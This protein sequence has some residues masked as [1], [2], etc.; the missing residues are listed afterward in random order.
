[1]RFAVENASA[2]LVDAFQSVVAARPDAVAAQAGHRKL[3][4]GQLDR[5][6]ADLARRLRELRVGRDA[7]VGVIAE[8]GLETVVAAVAVAKAGGAYAPLDPD[9]PRRRTL[10][11]LAHVR[12]TAVVAP[13]SLVDRVTG[14][15]VP[16]IALE[17]SHVDDDVRADDE[18][19]GTE[20][21]PSDLFAVVF[22]SGSSGR[23]K[24]VA[25]EHRNLLNLIAGAAE[26]LP[27]AGEGAL[28]ICA[29]QFDL[30]I[31]E[32]WATLLGGGRLVCHP[33]G[34]PD[35][36]A[37]R[38]TIAD[39]DVGWAFMATS[40][41]HQ[42]VESG[43]EELA[44]L[45]TL[46]AGGEAMHTGYARRFRA[47]CPGTQLINLYGPAETTVC[48]TA[49][50]VGDEVDGDAP[51]PIGRALAGALLDIRGPEGL[52]VESGAKGELWVGGAGV[53][54][55]YLHDPELTAERFREGPDEE[56][57]YR[58]GDIV[59]AREDGVL[60][61]FGRVDDQVKLRGY[62]VEPLEVEAHVL[63]CAGVARAAVVVQEPA[64]GR[65]RLA[66]FVVLEAGATLDS[67]RAELAQSLPAYMIPGAIVSV[68]E[69][70]VTP[71]GK[72]DRV[73]LRAAPVSTPAAGE[74]AVGPLTTTIAAV[75]AEV[76][77]VPAVGADDDFFAL[78]GDSLLAL[79]VVARL[80]ARHG[81]HTP[82][83]AI[84]Q[85]RTPTVVAAELDEDSGPVL[86]PLRARSHPE[87]VPA[88]AGQA[89]ALYVSELAEE[90]LP[91]QSQALHRIRGRLDVGALE[92][93]LSAI[94]ERHEILRTTFPRVD[95]RFVQSVHDPAPVRLHIEDLRSVADPE[96]ALEEH[97][98]DVV[99]LRLDPERLPLVRWSL[100]RVADD[101]HALIAVEHHVVHDGFTTARFLQELAEL[102]ASEVEDREPGLPLPAAQFRDFAAWQQEIADSDVG[103]RTLDH[104]L[105]RLSETPS[106]LMLPFD[107]PRPP[108]QTYR[109][110]TLRHTLPAT[111]AERIADRAAESGATVFAV[112]LAAY[113][114]LLA[115]TCSATDVVVGTGV[116]NRRTLA[117]EDVLGMVVNTVPLRVDLDGDPTVAE[118][119]ARVQEE[120]LAAHAHQ[121]VPFETVVSHLHPT[122]AANSTPV[123]QTLFAFHDSPVRTLTVPGATIVPRDALSN[124]SAKLDLSVV[125]INRRAATRAEHATLAEDGLTLVWEYNTDLFDHTTSERML[126]HYV[127][128][129]EHLATHDTARLG[130]LPL[131]QER[132]LQR[133]ARFERGG[134]TRYER[135]GTIDEVFRQR[136]RERPDAIAVSEPGGR[137]LRYG[138][139]ASWGRRLAQRLRLEGVPPGGRVAVCLD[140]SPEQV[141][142][143]LAVA[144]ARAAYVPLDPRD[145]PERLRGALASA[146][147]EL[148]LTHSRHYPDLHALPAR[149]LCVDELDLREGPAGLP[150]PDADAHHAAYVM[151]TSGSTG[152]PKGVEV[153]HRAILRLV[154]GTDYV[155]LGPDETLLAL[156]HPAFDASTFELW[157]ALLNGGRVVLAPPGPLSTA[158]L[159]ELVERERVTTLWLTAG[160]FHRVAE[161]RPELFGSLRQLLAGGDVLSPTHVRRAL[162]AL[163]PGGKFLNGYGP[164]E[165]TTFTAV[166]PLRSGDDVP[167]PVPIGRPIPNTHVRILDRWGAR[168]PIGGV[169]ELCIGG[170][171]VALGYAGDPALTAE[172]FVADTLEL[173][174][175]LYRSGDRARWR[176]DGTIEFLGRLD[177]QLKIRGFRVEPGEVEEA[178][179]RHPAVSDVHV[180]RYER[181][182]GDTGL[183]A[184][185]VPVS[186]VA[187]DA[188]EF[189]THVAR[190][191]PAH[192]V[193][194]A[195][196]LVDRLPLSSTGKVDA[197]ALL[198][199]AALGP[200]ARSTGRADSVERR[201]A[202][203]WERILDVDGVGADDD[204]FDLG[205]HSLLAV[206]MFDA[207]ERTFGSRLPLATVF[208][209]PTLGALAAVLRE[210]ERDGHG[211]LVALTETGTRPPLFFVTAGDGNAVGFGALARRL[212]PEQPFYALQQRG[213]D[214]GA[215]LHRSVERMAAHYLRA[216]RRVRPT[217]PYFLGGRCLGSAVAYEIAR[218]LR[219]AGED[220]P[221]LVV[222]DSGGPIS[223]Q[224][225][226]ADGTLYDEHMN[227][228]LRRALRGGI[229]LGDPFTP[230]GGER[231]LRWLEQPFAPPSG[232]P[233]SR[234]LH[235]V[236]LS[237][238]WLE[239]TFP[240]LSGVDAT[241]FL[242]TVGTR[243]GSYGIAPRFQ[244]RGA[245]PPARK[246][247]RM[248]VRDAWRVLLWRAAEVRAL[249]VGDR[250]PDA[251][252]R[253]RRRVSEAA[254]RAWT[255]YRAG[256]LDAVVTLVRSEEYEVHPTLDRWHGLETRGVRDATIRATHR[257]ILREPDVGAL[258]ELIASFVDEASATGGS[259]S[260]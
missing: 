54:R 199:P 44:G 250:L 22:T 86:P 247:L 127:A 66:A 220:V 149:V 238:P 165:G 82:L 83:A 90:S 174:Q 91:Y 88:T 135:D 256:A 162:G 239:E 204:F 177:R 102:Y 25:V 187:T 43:A 260:A 78:G 32:I 246:R 200:T 223:A 124:G 251:A 46:I 75:F 18:P 138:E 79:Q 129:L 259:R 181:E 4:Y 1:M 67:V 23:P 64:P 121:D 19:L 47:A 147:V 212:G 229:D 48:C 157:G 186:G 209:A 150:G 222:L 235:E 243:C 49:H 136:A 81:I 240:D 203:L 17:S 62:R 73:E 193:P 111:L 97:F 175:R 205:G 154:R 131:A 195:W 84:F 77:G 110:A 198:P 26:L 57:W 130:E 72:I 237:S 56:R 184:Y 143:Y 28:Q 160:L 11:Q 106:E 191:V 253:R 221:L 85:G 254:T 159:H 163:P 158:E 202:A 38:R 5:R 12:A 104:W 226:L 151:F 194:T 153:P 207:I 132:E 14:S 45:R 114:A 30:A 206:E 219:A 185:V 182:G 196:S 231:L 168:A 248:P 141:A 10:E 217:G 224:R 51:L 142:A 188:G 93:A 134:V 211:C 245:P 50:V 241:P 122:R 208:E 228:A 166:Y 39:H 13:A 148:V 69:L 107:R 169:G 58:S 94:V 20:T 139:L 230:D 2:S 146:G 216:I 161:D 105:E 227:A 236:Y 42:L 21:E 96:Q 249:V 115:R 16:V 120:V 255:S 98:A 218:R 125:V 70:P 145:P 225:R 244:P 6:A 80:E 176:E 234:Y 173:G 140:R 37:V 126:A 189:R 133:I 31:F 258:A 210:E 108:R 170:D 128:L 40:T 123:Y 233:V 103:R 71:N 59:R 60:E 214:G 89:K 27:L 52:P 101:D 172:R 167:D 215:L 36:V 29:P 116:A 242:D 201:L 24:A 180:A 3:T 33:P 95:G 179:R 55:G 119:I 112:M 137:A 156:A 178:L 117:G 190:L 41:F 183:A 68:A 155:D 113:A 118:L 92:R 213:L 9:S 171:G 74:D 76:L 252:E 109:G 53:S 99:R 100:A 15:E 34:R 152:E 8:R 257:S 192:A 63:A 65:K 197:G 164:T 232:E 7:V 144:T 87:L 35:P 61:I